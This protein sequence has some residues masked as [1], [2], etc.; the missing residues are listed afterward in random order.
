MIRIIYGVKD[1]SSVC[2]VIFPAQDNVGISNFVNQSL[3]KNDYNEQIVGK[4]FYSIRYIVNYY[5]FSKI[6]L[7]YDSNK[8]L[9]YRAYII[10][11]EKHE[12]YLD[13]L[14]QIEKLEKQYKNNELIETN[15]L[16][17]KIKGENHNAKNGTI[18]T[19]FTEKDELKQYFEIRENYEQYESI[20]FLS[21]KIRGSVEDPINA[22]RNC[23][24]VIKI[25][26]LNTNYYKQEESKTWQNTFKQIWK[27]RIVVLLF[28]LLLGMGG[29]KVYQLLTSN[30]TIIEPNITNRDSLNNTKNTED[31][32]T[33]K[34]HEDSVI[35]LS[36][37]P[38]YPP[39]NGNSNEIHKAET[40]DGNKV[41]T[42]NYQKQLLDSIQ[43]FLKE[44][45]KNI[46][47]SVI[48][49]KIKKYKE[50][51]SDNTLKGRLSYFGDFI[52]AIKTLPDPNKLESFCNIT[53]DKLN[54]EYEYVKFFE[55]LKKTYFREC[56]I[57]DGEILLT[58]AKISNI[59]SK[60]LT[61]IEDYYG[62]KN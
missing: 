30:E 57:K 13:I 54:S 37:F 51:V 46:N 47:I 8:R 23:D 56:K 27:S 49:D 6:Y 1:T 44:D 18:A 20:Y 2:E 32:D 26:M 7:V 28:G 53:I 29:M 59:G 12:T 17:D 14:D 15:P 50:K 10:A 45:S 41:K 9:S 48:S 19:Y 62:F 34:K 43:S 36:K 60:S 40:N 25:N 24:K 3:I 11:L 52:E 5:I 42:G 58:K 16:P 22:L 33:L 21:E 35:S 55:F 39:V 4:H 61:Q 38:N 31:I